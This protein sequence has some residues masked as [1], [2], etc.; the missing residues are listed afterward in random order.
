MRQSVN[1]SREI[2]PGIGVESFMASQDR[3]NPYTIVHVTTFL[4][5]GAGRTICELAINQQQLGCQTLVVA[6]EKSEPGYE[7]YP[8]YVSRLKEHGVNLLF[9]DSTFKR[10]LGLNLNAVKELKHSI[11]WD[12]VDIVHTHAAIPSLI[13]LIL[14]SR[15]RQ[16][17]PVVQTMHGWGLNKTPAQEAMDLVILNEVDRIIA[18]SHASAFLLREKRVRRDLI[19]IIPCG[20]PAE[21][22]MNIDKMRR[23]RV[24]DDLRRM[25]TEGRRILICIGTINENKNQRLVIEAMREMSSNCAYFCA[26]IGE[27]DRISGLRKL[28]R[29]YG[30]A[31]SVRF[32][33][34]QANAARYLPACDAAILPS[35]CEGQGLAAVEAFRDR[36]LSIG[37]NI[38]P[39]AE[40]IRE[41]KTG[42]LFESGNARS[43]ADAV[44]RAFDLDTASRK[45]I[46]ACAHNEFLKRFS[47]K[48]MCEAYWKLYKECLVDVHKLRG[49]YRTKRSFL[50]AQSRHDSIA[51]ML[52]DI[53]ATSESPVK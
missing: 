33:G 35:L 34:Y 6:S 23:D 7:N 20:L 42:F 5:G 13:A 8:E 40:M 52:G 46:L 27:G 37:S 45:K 49:S 32:Y 15:S 9:C 1:G 4:Q 53:N 11:D 22:V 10:D 28:A 44:Q 12:S 14:T 30:I 51:A 3:S 50:D 17:I 19:R 2:V 25:R 47:L 43:L 41:G 21:A 48:A 16:R 24:W 31:D 36:I 39:L 38:P 18:A 26:F 29:S